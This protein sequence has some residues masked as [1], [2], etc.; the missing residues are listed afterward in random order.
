MVT[1]DW[2]PPSDEI[3]ERCSLWEAICF[4][5]QVLNAHAKMEAQVGKIY[6]GFAGSFSQSPDL[7]QMWTTM[8]LEEGGHAALV[9]AVNRGL[10]SGTLKAKPIPLPL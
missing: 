10:L 1:I 6:I 7:R 5:D 9:H 4:F 3:S 2:R 8:A